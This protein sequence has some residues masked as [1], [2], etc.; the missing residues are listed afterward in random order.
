MAVSIQTEK[1]SDSEIYA[2]LH[3]LLGAWFK[4]KFKEFTEPQRFAILNIRRRENTL[5]TAPTGTG[6]TLSARN[7]RNARIVPFRPRQIYADEVH[8]LTF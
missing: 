2:S 6:K 3:P 7:N 5:I 4:W 8:G 1:H